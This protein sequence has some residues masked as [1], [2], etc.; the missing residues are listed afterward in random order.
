MRSRVAVGRP[1]ERSPYC[2]AALVEAYDRLA[3]PLQF[4]APAGELVA[5]VQIRT[6][7]RVLDVG[8]GTGTAAAAAA[9]IVGS[10][11]LV[12]GIDPS[13]EM[14]RR[15]RDNGSVR[16][17]TA[18]APDLPFREAC[19]DAVIGNF[20][21]THVEDPA[22]ALSQMMRVLRPGGRLG[23]T[24]W[25]DRGTPVSQIWDE[26][27]ALFTSAAG[28]KRV[29]QT[30][31][32]WEGWFTNATNLHG[33]LSEA[34]LSDVDVSCRE[35]AVTVSATDFPSMKEASVEGVL[36]RRQLSALDWQR[37]R[38]RLVEYLRSRL[39]DP[40]T[41]TRDAYIAVGTKAAG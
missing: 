5:A 29:C 2:D 10:E 12:V 35:Y 37:F 21:L 39:G 38:Q 36:L 13:Q 31:V 27:V 34:G 30:V 1:V 32:P 18:R 41:Y 11:G 17:T 3:V 8:T 4:A 40:V 28:L 9:V 22:R 16:V 6:S 19:F 33:A 24:S 25:G 20:V 14:L 7:H 23:V 26:V 15:L